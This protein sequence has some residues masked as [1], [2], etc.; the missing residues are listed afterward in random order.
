MGNNWHFSYDI[1]LQE[2]IMKVKKVMAAVCAA[3]IFS[4]GAFTGAVSAEE[5]TPH[6]LDVSQFV[7]QDENLVYIGASYLRDVSYLFDEQ[8]KVPET[9]EKPLHRG[10]RDSA[11]SQTELSDQTYHCVHH[12]TDRR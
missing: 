1:K 10:F 5:K 3:S 7:I 8:D 4:T 9:A 6:L 12:G 11:P 2:V